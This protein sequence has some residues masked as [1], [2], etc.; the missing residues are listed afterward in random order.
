M[1]FSWRTCRIMSRLACSRFSRQP[2]GKNIRMSIPFKIQAF[3]I[4]AFHNSI[5]NAVQLLK[6]VACVG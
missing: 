5:I 2:V 1:K 6:Y 3:K 4:Q